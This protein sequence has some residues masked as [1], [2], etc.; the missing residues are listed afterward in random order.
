MK[1]ILEK[2][3]NNLNLSQNDAYEVMNGIIS[4]KYNDAQISGFLIALRSKG[5]TSDE[6]AGFTLAMKNKMTKVKIESNAIDMCGTGGDTKGTF[7]ISTAASFVVAASGIKV[8]KHGNRSM[9]SKSGSADVLEA[10]GININ[11]PPNKVAQ[12]I[13]EIGLGFMFA[14]A[15][16]PAMKYALEARKSLAVRTVFNMLGPLCNPANVKR[17]VMGIFDGNL[18]EKIA[19]ALKKLGSEKAYIIH[20][21]DGLDEITTTANTKIT[22]LNQKGNI[23]SNSFNPQEYNFNLTSLEKLKGGNPIDNSKIIISILKGKKG[24]HRDIVIL[25]SAFGIKVGSKSLSLN[26]AINIANDSIDSGAAL[27]VLERLKK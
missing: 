11:Y 8:A 9:T 4:G 24:V 13:E 1:Q 7:N 27:N 18:T 14:P 20:G 3:L 12:Q 6:I 23:S 19:K 21:D 25:N 10:L 26:E 17:Q 22:Y 5:E 15:L 16:H 2:L